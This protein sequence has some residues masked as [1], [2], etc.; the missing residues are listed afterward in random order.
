MYPTAVLELSN[1]CDLTA[2]ATVGV[3][4]SRARTIRAEFLQGLL[5]F[6]IGFAVAATLLEPT[7][8]CGVIEAGRVCD[9]NILVYGRPRSR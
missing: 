1:A 5:R 3:S 9:P 7:I 8:L 4:L 2:P 6:V